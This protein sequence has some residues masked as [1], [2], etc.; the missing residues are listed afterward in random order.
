MN[1]PLM[2]V[3]VLMLAG[4]AA[5]KICAPAVDTRAVQDVATA[6]PEGGFEAAI[7][8]GVETD[9]EP[10]F[11][12][13]L[14]ARMEG[15]KSV[16]EFTITETHG[17]GVKGVLVR[18]WHKIKDEETGEWIEDPDFS[19]NPFICNKPLQLGQPL[20]YR[21]VLA[22]AELDQLPDGLLGSSEEWGAE[23]AGERGVFKRA[24]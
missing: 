7:A 15:S 4:L 12:L 10:E 9:E 21:T 14:E 19:T 2:I 6:R 24:D 11:D 1:K 20:V 23:V 3:L 5:W 18:F 13:Q 8:G 16:L 22:E 17:W